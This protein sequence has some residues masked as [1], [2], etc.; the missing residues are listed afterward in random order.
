MSI[1]RNKLFFASTKKPITDTFR[2]FNELRYRFIDIIDKSCDIQ[3]ILLA[4]LNL[5]IC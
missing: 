5:R 3:L 2:L 1:L 4:K